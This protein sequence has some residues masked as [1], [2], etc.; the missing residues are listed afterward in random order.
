MKSINLYRNM[1][2]KKKIN[3]GIELLR[4][5]L[6]FLIVYIH[7]YN[8]TSSNKKLLLF[9]LLFLE[10][11][12]P[13]FFIISFYFSHKT[14]ES[15]NINKLKERFKRI[16]IPY[17]IWPI[18]FWLKYNFFNILYRKKDKEIFKNLYYQLLN[19]SIIEKNNF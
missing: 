7:C 19:K 4:M 8:T 12:V 17:I 6:T 3:L 16:L 9:T 14:F 2:N 13:T 1:K 10:F 15:K 11:F 5:I 18:I